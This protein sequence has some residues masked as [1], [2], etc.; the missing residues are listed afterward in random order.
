MIF[1]AIERVRRLQLSC[2]DGLILQ[3][4]LKSGCTL[5]L[6]EDLQHGQRIGNLR[7]ENPFL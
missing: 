6:S 2:W 5:V 1:S 7:I 4:A 3:A